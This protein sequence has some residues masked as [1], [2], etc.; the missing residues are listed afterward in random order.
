M[1]IWIALAHV[2]P[3]SPDILDG[4]KG[5][6]IQV[7][8]HVEGEAELYEMACAYLCNQSLQVIDFEDI[9]PLSS[10]LERDPLSS[11][12]LDDLRKEIGFDGDAGPLDIWVGD[13][14]VYMADDA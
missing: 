3:D 7:A 5:G 11:E 4:G 14:H 13:L 8:A 1:N 12:E 9:E 2:R 10:R 6:F